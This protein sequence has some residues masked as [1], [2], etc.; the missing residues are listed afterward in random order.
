M[1]WISRFSSAWA[2]VT[3]TSSTISITVAEV[4]SISLRNSRLRRRMFLRNS[5]TVKP[6]T[7]AHRM[8][9]TNTVRLVANTTES[10]TIM[11]RIMLSSE[12]ITCDEKASIASTSRITLD[13]MRPDSISLWKVMDSC[14]SLRTIAPRSPASTL[15]V[16]RL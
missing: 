15:R 1:R 10:A 13:W 16:A 11:L 9:N 12:I 8:K 2:R 6:P 7:G 14:C 4:R 5:C 3:G